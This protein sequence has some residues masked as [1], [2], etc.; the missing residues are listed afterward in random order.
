MKSKPR[1]RIIYS[2][3]LTNIQRTHLVP[4]FVFRF[5]LSMR[6]SVD[7][8]KLEVKFKYKFFI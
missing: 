3:E 2:R 6:G 1:A 8:T 4:L 7:E 5:F